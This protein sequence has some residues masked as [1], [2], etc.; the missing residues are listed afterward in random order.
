MQAL[1][2]CHKASQTSDVSKPRFEGMT[3]KPFR[4]RFDGPEFLKDLNFRFLIC[5]MPYVPRQYLIASFYLV[6]RGL[7]HRLRGYSSLV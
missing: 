6:D 3:R 5:V 4:S 2:A 1:A 7:R